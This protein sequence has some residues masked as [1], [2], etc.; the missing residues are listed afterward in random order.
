M[1]TALL[2]IILIMCGLLSANQADTLHIFTMPQM[3]NP[4]YD[5]FSRN[6]LGVEASGRGYTGSSILGSAQSFALNPAAMLVD[7]ARVFLEANIKPPLDAEGLGYNSRYSSTSPIS[8]FGFSF[9][10]GSRFAAAISYNNPK[11]II[12][13]DFSIEINQG[14]DMITR[15][16]TYFVHQG[17]ASLAYHVSD[18]LH[19]GLN[20]HN[21]LHYL[22]DVLFLRT[23]DR[24]KDYKYSLRV[25]PGIIYGN[26]HWGA[27]LSGSLPT[28]IKWDLKYA[29]YDT[30]L[31]LEINAGAHY[32]FDDYRVAADVRYRQDSEINEVFNDHYSMHLGGEKR[33]LNNIFRAGYFYSSDVFSGTI[34][35]PMN[36]TASADTSMFWDAVSTSLPISDTAQHFVSL[37]FT[38]LFR[39]G[40][41][42][43]ALMHALIGE[44]RQT[45]INLSLSLYL[46]SFR[47]KDF[48][49]YE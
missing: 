23:Y 11:S 43:L 16:P 49:Y 3:I 47:R 33:V 37:G 38:H 22:D 30:E 28:P 26:N 46:S 25:Q 32:A 44:Q 19:L 13:D 29:V 14:A 31:P 15:Y 24:Q 41:L 27:G 48:L 4:I 12:L 36:S 8:M 5:F 6:Y 42:N 34:V 17:T 2:A 45:Q 40:S 39:D 21:Q 1:R 20:L 7:S 9:P 35:L 10:L 18:K